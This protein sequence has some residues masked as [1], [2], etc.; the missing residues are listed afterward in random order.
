MKIGIIGAGHIGSELYRRAKSLNWDI[1]FVLRSDGVYRNLNE[2]VDGLENYTNYVDDI[3]IGFLAIPTLDDG[4][5][6]FEYM[7][8][9]LEREIPMVTCEKGALA[10]YFSKLEPRLDKIGYSATVGG[11]TRLL[12][13]S[14]ERMSSAVREIHAVIN[15][16]LN[17]IFDQVSRGRSLGEVVDETKT[18][19]YSEPGAETA[20]D[21]INKEATKDV[22]MKCSI[23][24]NICFRELIPE[25]MK[26]KDVTFDKIKKQELKRLVREAT[27]RR[28]IVS[29]TKENNQEDVIGGFRHKVGDWFISAGFKNKNENPL[30][31]QLIPSGVNN[32][33]LIYEGRYGRDGTYRLSGQG[34]GAGPTA[35]SMITDAVKLC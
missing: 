22:P 24:F 20:L 15:G 10:N 29:I 21:V 35:S 19:G 25:R 28:Y 12:G 5:R 16:T 26:A 33:I 23:L 17:H 1:E 32:A 8:F 27:N 2:K 4:K 13:Y 6:A 30:F 18:L 11:G 14:E 34:A 31:L 7:N 3:E 9:L